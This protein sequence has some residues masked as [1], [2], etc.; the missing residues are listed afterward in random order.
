MAI[1]P[2]PYIKDQMSYPPDIMDD[3]QEHLGGTY[4]ESLENT[5]SATE[6]LVSADPEYEDDGFYYDENVLE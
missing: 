6:N 3:T 5:R 4:V 2:G 1:S